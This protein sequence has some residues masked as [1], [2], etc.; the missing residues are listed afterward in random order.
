MKMCKTFLNYI[1][2]YI[3]ISQNIAIATK[4]PQWCTPQRKVLLSFYWIKVSQLRFIFVLY[5]LCYIHSNKLNN[6]DSNNGILISKKIQYYI[7]I[8]I[9]MYMYTYILFVSLYLY[10]PDE[11]SLLPK[12]RDCTTSNDI[13]LYLMSCGVMLLLLII[14]IYMYFLNCSSIRKSALCIKC[15]AFK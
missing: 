12:H 13:E 11:G 8:Y 3:Y 9:Y 14:Y 5:Y 2:R 7:Y 1:L 6:I 4:L 10:V 15:R